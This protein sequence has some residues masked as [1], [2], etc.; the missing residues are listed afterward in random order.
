MKARWIRGA[1]AVLLLSV[2]HGC[3]L[4]SKSEPLSP[5][6]YDPD[7][8]AM[9]VRS[10]ADSDASPLRGAVTLRLGRVTAAAH[11]G[12]RMVYRSGSREIGFSDERRWTAPPDWYLRRALS[13]ALFERE[14]VHRSVGSGGITLDIELTDF[15]ELRTATKVAHARATFVLYDARSV[16]RER[17]IDV[18]RP[19]TVADP[20]VEVP[21]EAVV[22]AM[23][24]ALA[25][26]VN[27]VTS[28]VLADL[29][30]A[31]PP[32]VAAAIDAGPPG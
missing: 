16:I 11:L 18:E 9:S 6:Y 14:G 15:E 28:M 25:E 7:L 30:K 32:P 24:Q 4:T 8:A 3:A 12:E 13:A 19:I 29:A 26:L 31:A 5:H 22:Q 20:R 23:S 21:A 2:A 17:T 27:R 10:A 1:L